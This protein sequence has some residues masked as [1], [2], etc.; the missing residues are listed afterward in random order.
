MS[1]WFHKKGD[2]TKL[3]DWLGL[4]SR[5]DSAVSEAIERSG[6][7]WSAWSSWFA[8]FRLTGWTRLANEFVSEGF[9]LAAGGAV[10]MFALA[11][12][13]L[14]EFDESKF[15]TGRYSVK[16]LDQAGNEI[17]K[18]GILH[19]DAV[20]LD[21]IPR[22]M[23]NATLATE[24]RRF[25]DHFGID[26]IGTTRALISNVQSN[27]S[28]Q[29]GST[30]TQQLAK[31]LFLSSERSLT[32]KI[33]ELYLAFLLEARFTKREILKLYLDRAYMGGGAFGVEAASQYYFGKSVREVTLAEAALL[34]GL[35]KAPTKFAPHVNLPAAR[36]R[37][38][39]VLSNLVE[40]GFYTAG[41]VHLARINPAK[42]VENRAAY[43]P[44]W[45]LDHAFEEVQ[46]LAE[47]KNQFVLIARTTLDTT[48]QRAADEA[49]TST[50]RSTGRQKNF[51]SGSLV[52]METDGA[53]KA[54][55]G[56][57]D[58][59]ESQ[60]NRATH[61]KRQPGSSF[62]PYVYAAALE[63]G[64]FT[65]R[66]TAS[67][68]SPTCGNWS[69]KNYSGGGS[70]GQVQ[71]GDAF[72]RSLNTVAVYLSLNVGRAKVVELTRRLGIKGIIPSCSMA[73][74]DTG[75]TPLEHTGAIATFANNGKL[76]KPYVILEITN[77]KG[78]VLYSH[79]RDEPPAPQVVSKKVV[80]QMNQ[81]MQMVVTQGTGKNAA[82][83]FTH[84]VGKTGTSSSYK[85]A[86]FVGFTGRYVASV[87]LGN[88]DNRPMDD[89]TGGQG[90]AP[91]W[92]QFMSIIHTSMNIPTIPGLTPHP[93]QIEE[94]R[95]LAELQRSEPELTAAANGQSDT[96][97]KK[98]IS[99]MPDPTR[100]ALKK[101]GT[102]F[103]KVSGLPE[104][105]PANPAA[106]APKPAASENAPPAPAGSSGGQPAGKPAASPPGRRADQ[107]PAAT[108]ATIR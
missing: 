53:V 87:W 3:V 89:V 80:D 15:L 67:D 48:I 73:L 34:A 23:I 2:K 58:Y 38:A 46:R 64:G 100:T 6:Q 70:G 17:G 85:D 60:F 51:N 31:N 37:T 24:D 43:S 107:A 76:A 5:V 8:R 11:L 28:V 61:A 108:G 91:A 50:I 97:A 69:P 21:E 56:G 54:I 57:P 26:L 95:R 41:Q 104:E 30:L 35:Y 47:G 66:S 4:D 42:V 93:V 14:Q 105:V 68:S 13:A 83:E 88:D 10:V 44:D 71:L 22:H 62:K 96:A 101:L 19:N 78:D 84:A 40:A 79:E 81:M 103:R 77:S 55:V 72:A 18:R 94:Q 29:G 98:A 7:T 20:P 16:L 86:W 25:F 52:A 45:F 106:A 27:A 75:I 39:E 90:P 59:G 74:G 99:V 82:L 92:K 33:K 63:S 36:A 9:T 49:L 32:R 65:I 12:P 1:D 102:A